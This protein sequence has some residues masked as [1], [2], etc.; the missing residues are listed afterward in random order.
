[1]RPGEMQIA[2]QKIGQM[3]PGLDLGRD[4]GT[5]DG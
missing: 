3:Q 4:R 2:A 1:M 5:V